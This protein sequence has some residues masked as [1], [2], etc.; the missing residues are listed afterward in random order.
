[1]CG[2]Q[3]LTLCLGPG[4]VRMAAQIGISAA[5]LAT[6]SF[7]YTASIYS[8]RLPAAPPPPP[9]PARGCNR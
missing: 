4:A 3:T 2:L 6:T 1:M 5:S 8:V 7:N 9:P